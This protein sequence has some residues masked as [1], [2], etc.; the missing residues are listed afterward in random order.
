MV[1]MYYLQVIV[2]QKGLLILACVRDSGRAPDAVAA[3]KSSPPP[4]EK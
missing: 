4:H 3:G 2:F 1:I